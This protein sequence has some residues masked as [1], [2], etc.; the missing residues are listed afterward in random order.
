[1]INLN[2][3]VPGSFYKSGDKDGFFADEEIRK[4]WAV[5]LDLLVQLDKMCKK[6][7]LSYVAGA[8]TLLGAVRHKGFIPWDDDIDIYMLRPDYDKL[9]SLTSEFKY[10]YFLQNTYTEKNLFRTHAQLR[11]SETTGYIKSD[12]NRDIN[13]GLFIDIFPLDGI[14]DSGFKD[15]IQAF[16]N[17]VLV[18]LLR[19]Y[20]Y[21]CDLNKGKGFQLFKAR[22]FKVFY[23]FVDKKFIFKLYEKNLK[24]YSVKGTK[25][26]GNRTLVFDCPKSRR[27]YKDWVN[28]MMVPFEFIK[29]PISKSYDSM[30]RQQYKD[31]MKIPEQKGCNF[32]GGLTVSTDIPYYKYNKE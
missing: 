11:N 10:P 29:I 7:G 31:Y 4:V 14:S 9:M 21:S 23:L 20:N 15:R 3:S 22:L 6:H 26:W 19:Q 32:H 13:K 25:L 2:I 27:P 8:G 17:N 12:E 28:L 24:K 18:K 30:L 1:M 5:E 16:W